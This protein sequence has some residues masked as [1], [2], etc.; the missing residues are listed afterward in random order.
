MMKK[1][2]LAVFVS[3][4]CL[5]LFAG[6][7]IAAEEEVSQKDIEKVVKELKTIKFGLKW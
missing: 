5:M 4:C 2:L 1:K 7:S 3:L 6:V